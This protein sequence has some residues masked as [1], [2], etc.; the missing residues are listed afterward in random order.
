M[1]LTTEQTRQLNEIYT[2][3]VRKWRNNSTDIVLLDSPPML[4][5]DDAMRLADLEL[6]DRKFQILSE[7]DQRVE[8]IKRNATARRIMTSPHVCKMLERALDRKLDLL[9]RLENQTE[10]LA[11][12]I[13][14]ESKRNYLAFEREKANARSRS[15]RDYANIQRMR[16]TVPYNAQSLIDAEIYEAYLAWCLQFPPRDAHAMVTGNRIFGDNLLHQNWLRLVNELRLR[17]GLSS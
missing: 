16:L 2:S 17:A 4:S 6:G 9:S 3:I 5:M 8:D 12:R 14:G 7:Y 10:R 15:L 1:I 13:L 11:K